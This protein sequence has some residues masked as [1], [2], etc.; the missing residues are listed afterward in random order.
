M[1][2][3]RILSLCYVCLVVCLL[4]RGLWRLIGKYWRYGAGEVYR[5]LAIGSQVKRL[6]RFVPDLRLS[7]VKRWVGHTCPCGWWWAR[8]TY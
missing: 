8:H 1:G 4:F 2:V 7:D 6:Q 5:S 3:A